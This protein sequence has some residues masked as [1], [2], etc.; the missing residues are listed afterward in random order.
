MLSFRKFPEAKMFMEKKGGVSRV[1]VES[2]LS[3][4]P[5][6]FRS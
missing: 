1:S 5:E 4:F 6:K 2:F 3:H